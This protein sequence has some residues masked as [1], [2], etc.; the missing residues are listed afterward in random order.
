MGSSALS[1]PTSLDKKKL[2]APNALSNSGLTLRRTTSKILPTNSSLLPTKRW[3]RFSVLTASVL[4][5]WLNTSPLTCHKGFHRRETP[6][7]KTQET[8][9]TLFYMYYYANFRPSLQ[10]LNH[11]IM[12]LNCN[13]RY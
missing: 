5:V 4:S 3:P 2:A 12:Y 7:F 11:K 10:N 8:K 13:N 9:M 1:S 6:K